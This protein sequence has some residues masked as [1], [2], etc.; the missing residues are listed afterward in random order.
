MVSQITGVS[1]ACSTA[2]SKKISKL[3][4]TGLCVGN[5]PVTDE[6][7]AQSASNAENASIWWRHHETGVCLDVRMES[8]A[9]TMHIHG[10]ENRCFHA[11]EY[12]D[13]FSFY[14]HRYRNTVQTWY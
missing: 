14:A 6:F 9:C 10:S 11:V 5:S 4:V 2:G 12:I 8:R 13:G 7:P 3:P 1:I